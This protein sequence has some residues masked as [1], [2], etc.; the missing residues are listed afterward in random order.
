MCFSSLPLLTLSA[1]TV[2]FLPPQFW[3]KFRVEYGQS[4][5]IVGGNKALGERLAAAGT[6][7]R[8]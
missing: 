4:L 8:C 6:H 1:T 2:N 3:L 5:R 7:A